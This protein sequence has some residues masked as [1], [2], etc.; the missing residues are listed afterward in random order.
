MPETY[1]VTL[2]DGRAFNVT[3][4]GGPPSEADVLG[5]LS[6]ESPAVGAHPEAVMRAPTTADPVTLGELQD[7]PVE[8]MQ[9]IGAILKKDVSDPKLWLSA[10]AAYFGPKV[11]TSASRMMPTRA[12][13]RKAASI[14]GGVM[15]SPIAGALSPRAAHVGRM[16]TAA[17]EQL[18]V[19]RAPM[20]VQPGPVRPPIQVEPPVVPPA[21]AAP[22]VTAP[23]SGARPSVQDTQA[24]LATLRAHGF[25]VNEYHPTRGWLI[26]R[27]AV[28]DTTRSVGGGRSLVT[29]KQA[30]IK[31]AVSTLNRAGEEHVATLLNAPPAA[32]APKPVMTPAAAKFTPATALQQAKDAF[33]AAHATPQPG[34]LSWVQAYMKAG[35]SPEAAVAKALTFRPKPTTSAAEALAQ[36][37]GTPSDVEVAQVVAAKNAKTT[38]AKGGTK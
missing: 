16:L 13:V 12:T 5:S 25:D 21:P 34:E 28:S 20:P 15:E 10:A 30:I 7:N 18:Q 33:A 26:E 36:Q 32:S 1:R 4:E 35:L 8:A 6:S 27:S 14:A 24:A 11:L 37:F 9:R 17:G 22:P 19:P 38:R 31:Q 23:A 29:P 3:T 2:S